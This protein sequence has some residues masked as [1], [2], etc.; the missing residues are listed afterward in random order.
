MSF[1]QQIK[2]VLNSQPIPLT[3]QIENITE[4]IINFKHVVICSSTYLITARYDLYHEHQPRLTWKVHL[5]WPMELSY[6]ANF[7]E[8][9]GNIAVINDEVLANYGFFHSA[10]ILNNLDETSNSWPNSAFYE[11][12]E[13]MNKNN[14][15]LLNED[16]VFID[17]KPAESQMLKMKLN[18]QLCSN[19]SLLFP[20]TSST[21][22][23]QVETMLPQVSLSKSNSLIIW[24]NTPPRQS[25]YSPSRSPS[26]TL[27][28]WPAT[29]PSDSNHLIQRSPLRS[30]PRSP[31]RIT[32]LAP[33]TRIDAAAGSRKSRRA[34]KKNKVKQKLKHQPVMSDFIRPKRANYFPF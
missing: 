9:F 11:L 10:A 31:T 27:D 5:I 3:S 1:T 28:N 14:I 20:N 8:R 30:P 7:L 15:K 4:C 25:G 19:D 26:D 2:I 29:L 22:I 17:I 21:S 6:L 32:S 16:D 34:L 13:D 12:L 23:I 33:K 24:P 18:M